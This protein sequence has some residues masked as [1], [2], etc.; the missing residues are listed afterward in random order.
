MKGRSPDGHRHVRHALCDG[1]GLRSLEQPQLSVITPESG[2][3]FFVPHTKVWEEKYFYILVY[4]QVNLQ[5]RKVIL[6]RLHR[7]QNIIKLPCELDCLF[8]NYR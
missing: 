7:F 8:L 4:S 6:H 3:D 2:E 5:K 1:A